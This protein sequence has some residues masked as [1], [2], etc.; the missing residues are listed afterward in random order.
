VL[1]ERRST[2][3]RND[4]RTS[5]EKDADNKKKVD[6]EENYNRGKIKKTSKSANSKHLV[7]IA[8][9][10]GVNLGNDVEMI[11]QN[12]DACKKFEKGMSNKRTNTPEGGAYSGSNIEGNIEE[13][14]CNIVGNVS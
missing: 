9:N 12:I 3:I 14:E 5:L 13:G 8:S 4:G 6:L 11:D 7:H 2:R 10:V 1:A